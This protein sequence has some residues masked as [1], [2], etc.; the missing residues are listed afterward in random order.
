MLKKTVH[1]I[2][3]GLAMAGVASLL[4]LTSNAAQARGDVSWSIGVNTP[5]VAVGVSNGHGYPV[6]VAPQPVYV[7][8]RPIYYAPPAPVYYAPPRP[9]YYAP[10]VYAPAPGYYYG[11]HG[12]RG[13]GHGHGHGHRRD[14]D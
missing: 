2:R 14:R 1:L 13:R 12:H 11:G 8:P 7:Q 5:G 3:A 9:I 6:Y 10:P 4:A